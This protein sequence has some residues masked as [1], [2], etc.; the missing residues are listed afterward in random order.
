MLAA[1]WTVVG[2]PGIDPTEDSM[3]ALRC[4]QPELDAFVLSGQDISLTKK[5]TSSS[6]AFSAQSCI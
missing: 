1:L 3:A 4:Y 6:S 2:K 5:E